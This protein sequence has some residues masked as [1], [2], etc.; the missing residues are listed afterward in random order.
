[1]L[2]FA[3]A[4]I[5]LLATFLISS[6]RELK[7]KRGEIDQ[8]LVK[9]GNPAVAADENEPQDS[10][11]AAQ[12]DSR[13]QDLVEQISTLSS[14][15]QASEASI[16]DLQK[17]QVRLNA[18]EVEISELR[19]ANEQLQREAADLKLQLESSRVPVDP[20]SHEENSAEQC[21]QLLNEIAQLKDKLEQSQSEVQRLANA[22]E[23]LGDARAREL[24]ATEQQRRLERERAGL[25]SDAAAARE[26]LDIAHSRIAEAETVHE[27]LRAENQRLQNDLSAC[28]DRVA[29]IE[30]ERLC[31]HTARRQ[32]DE[33]RRTHASCFETHQSIEKELSAVAL[34]LEN[35]ATNGAG[36]VYSTHPEASPEP[37]V[38]TTG[39]AAQ[40]D[41]TAAG[42]DSLRVQSITAGDPCDM[43]ASQPSAFKRRRFGIFTS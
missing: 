3:G 16:E 23:Q 37:E 31:L 20:E 25:Q 34:L 18:A 30:G 10:P 4:T 2:V 29:E 40:L 38:G 22:H 19:L 27:N 41:A 6:E 11:G 26:Q 21:V 17:T 9:V 12:L 5:G 7:K 35:T 8:L 32:L 24:I 13:Q 42:A 36:T 28:R 15:L 39:V 33:I 1:M 43:P 14:K